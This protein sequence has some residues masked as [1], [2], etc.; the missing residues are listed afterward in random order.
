MEVWKYK[1]IEV[2]KN[3]RMK[4]KSME[5][6]VDLNRDIRSEGMRYGWIKRLKNRVNE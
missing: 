4:K 2:Y 5:K 1:T 6:W 3:Q